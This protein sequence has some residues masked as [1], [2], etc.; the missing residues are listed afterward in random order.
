MRDALPSCAVCNA[1]LQNL[2]DVYENFFSKRL[3]LF[4]L[5]PN[6]I[7]GATLAIFILPNSSSK[8]VERKVLPIV[9]LQPGTVG[10]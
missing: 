3:H 9:N 1:K 5:F 10:V 7:F 8:N 6:I 4:R 2:I